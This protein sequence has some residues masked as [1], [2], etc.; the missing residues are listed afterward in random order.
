MSYKAIVKVPLLTLLI[1]NCSLLIGEAQVVFT[2][3]KCK[4]L[5]LKNNKK[6]ENAQL[7]VEKAE[8]TKKEAFTKYFPDV[9]AT[10]MGMLFNKAPM[11]TMQTVETGYPPPNDLAEVEVE[12]FKNGIIGSVVAVQPIFAGGQLVNGNR[13]AQKGVEVSKLQQQMVSDE[14][15]L[16]TESYY[17][18]LVSLKEKTK[19]IANAETMLA[20]VQSDV[21]AAVEAG[22]TTRNDLTR[23]ELEQNRLTSNRLKLDNAVKM[24]KNA[25][26]LHIGVAADS[27]DIQQPD[28]GSIALPLAAAASDSI[29]LQSR[30]EYQLLQKGV[31]AAQLQVKMEV[32]KNLP[33][34]AIGAG[35]TYLN[36][37]NYVQGNDQRNAMEKN[38]GI[39]LATVSV[40]ISGWWGG[41]HAIKKR[42][43]E[44]RAAE[45]TRAE[46]ADLLR[47]QMQ[48]LADELSEAYEQ[49]SIAQKSIAVASD[50]AQLCENTYNAGVSILSDLLDAQNLLQQSRDQHTEAATRY[51]LKLAEY[52][53]A[54]GQ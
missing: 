25:F 8:H 4:E 54:T 35:Y 45:N 3:E 17:W 48:R 31:E 51:F 5:A 53:Q 38:M 16:T 7:S 10:G 28:F 11:T 52:R 9:S 6:V 43:L 46:T 18:Q 20:R 41:S 37:G 40:P 26:G 33:T 42:K 1:I 21:K 24:L 15:L 19:T 36:I 22:L 44:L 49:V 32:G 12:M 50:N 30:P 47:L 23:V 13:L 34:I 29:A 39:A 14:T 27:F 2:L